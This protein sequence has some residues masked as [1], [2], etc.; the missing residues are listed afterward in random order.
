MSIDEARS[1]VVESLGRRAGARSIPNEYPSRLGWT[2]RVSSARRRSRRERAAG[3]AGADGRHHL[4]D[5]DCDL[6]HLEPAAHSRCGARARDCRAARPRR[7]PL[8]HHVRC[9]RRRRR[10]SRV[11]GGAV[12]FLASLW[13]VDLLLRLV[14]DGCPACR[15]IAVDRSRLPVR[16]A[17]RRGRRP[18]GRS[19]SRAAVGAHRRRRSPEVVRQGRARRH[20]GPPAQRAGGRAGRDRRSCCSSA[21]ACWCAASGTCKPSRPACRR[22]SCSRCE[23]GCRSRTI[24]SRGPYFEHPQARRAD[25]RRHR[26]PRRVWRRS[27]MLGLATALPAMRDSGSPAFAVEGLDAGSQ[28]T[29][30]AATVH[31]GH[32]GLFPGAWRAAGAAGGCSHESRRS[33]ARRARRSS[34]RRSRRPTS[35]ARILSGGASTSSTVAVRSHPDAHSRSRSSASSAT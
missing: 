32:A 3:A 31:V 25:P 23:S 34:T 29:W 27:V 12:G 15:D 13:G 4:R 11:A 17:D 14:P 26:S 8:A 6:E 30:R 18:A 2:P 5:A 28:A 24:P 35:A 9:A 16:A 7:V 10:C 19:R 1:R 20:A 33:N 21:P 22:R